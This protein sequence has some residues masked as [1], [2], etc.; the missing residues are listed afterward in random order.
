[1]RQALRSRRMASWGPC[2]HPWVRGTG[3]GLPADLTVLS[4][5][6]PRTANTK[7]LSRC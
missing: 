1:M 7:V 2:S 3:F 5:R 6:E 4:P